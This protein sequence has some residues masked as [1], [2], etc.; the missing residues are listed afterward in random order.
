M[1]MFTAFHLDEG[2]QLN[3]ELSELISVGIGYSDWILDL[4]SKGVKSPAPG[5]YQLWAA[6]GSEF[7]FEDAFT[8]ESILNRLQWLNFRPAH[9]AVAFRGRRFYKDKSPGCPARVLGELSSLIDS[10]GVPHLPKYV[11]GL[12]RQHIETY[13][14][15]PQATFQPDD[16]FIVA[17]G[18]VAHV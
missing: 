12:G 8:L 2:A 5:L 9:P 15:W 6:Q 7:G 16:V 10:D 1:E 18:T 4:A 13:W 11:C 3:D 14:A 17:G